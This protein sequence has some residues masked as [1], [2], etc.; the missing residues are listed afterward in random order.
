[1]EGAPSVSE[2]STYEVVGSAYKPQENAISRFL[3]VVFNFL[4]I[5]K[6]EEEIRESSPEK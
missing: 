2:S 4:N 5:S 1:M 6:M 3:F